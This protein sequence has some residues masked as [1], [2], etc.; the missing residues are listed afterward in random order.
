MRN[1]YIQS[2]C[3]VPVLCLFALTG[4]SQRIA[5]LTGISTKNIYTKGTDVGSLPK[6]ANVEGYHI[7]FLGIGANL[8]EAID[9]ALAKGDGNLMID[10]RIYLWSAPFF[11]GFKV[12]GDIVSVPY[13]PGG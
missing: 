12:R 6:N 13:A 7:R 10:C 4:C 3:F 1:R 2:A 8:E 5:D 9:D 11:S